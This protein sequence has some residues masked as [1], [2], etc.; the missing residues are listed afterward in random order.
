VDQPFVVVQ[1]LVRVR[2]RH[3]RHHRHIHGGQHQ[4]RSLERKRHRHRR[5]RWVAADSDLGLNMLWTVDDGGVYRAEWEPPFDAP[6][7]RYR[8]LVHANRYQLTSSPFTLVP[9]VGLAAQR[10]PAAPGR[11]AIDLAYPAPVSR[12]A[13]GDPAGDDSA[14]LSFRPATASGGGVAFLVDG[15]RR[16]VRASGGVFSV[17]ANPGADVIVLSGAAQDQ[18]GNSDG[19]GLSFQ[20]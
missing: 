8:F 3:H 14:D 5:K 16:R 19:T 18:F 2:K 7:G 13:V 20:G 12:E 1:R 15:V 4:K 10:V 9:S 17:A 6:L 11:V